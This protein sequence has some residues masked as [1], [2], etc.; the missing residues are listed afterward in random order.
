MAWFVPWS[1]ALFA[2][3]LRVQTATPD[4]LCPDPVQVRGAIAA[5]VGEVE[6]A[7]AGEWLASYTVVHRPDNDRAD[8]IRLELFDPAGTLR[9][10]RDLPRDGESCAA[11]AQAIAVVLDLHFRHPSEVEPPQSEPASHPAATL[12]TVASR[13]ADVDSSPTPV[14]AVGVAGGWAVGRS[15]PALALEASLS[16]LPSW[17]LGLELAWMAES[18]R[19]DLGMPA[20][21]REA[22]IRSGA[23][24]AFLARRLFRDSGLRVLVGPELVATMDHATLAGQG[25]KPQWRGGWGIGGRTALEIGVAPRLALALALSADWTPATLAGELVVNETESVPALE[26]PRLRALMSLAAIYSFSR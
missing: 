9:L 15:S 26:P 14:F 24:R 25:N 3:G 20:L 6:V 1:L 23:G 12:S 8:L 10:R 19:T 4:A 7:G 5:R 22:S 2:A 11:M 21:G 16:V 13:S 17:V 18:W